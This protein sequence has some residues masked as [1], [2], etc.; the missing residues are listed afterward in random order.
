LTDIG[1]WLVFLLEL[2]FLQKLTVGFSRIFWIWIDIVYQST[3][4][5]KLRQPGMLHNGRIAQL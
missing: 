5:T 3:S 1:F 2:D 4:G